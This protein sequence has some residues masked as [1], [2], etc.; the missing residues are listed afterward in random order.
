MEG[1]ANI[2]IDQYQKTY[3]IYLVTGKHLQM[4][5]TKGPLDGKMRQ[6]TL[7]YTAL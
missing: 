6:F 5:T 1:F 7:E 2:L 4:L 3:Q